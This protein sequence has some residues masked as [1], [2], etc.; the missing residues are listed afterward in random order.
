MKKLISALLACVMLVM[1]IGFVP[2]FAAE[3]VTL[4]SDNFDASAVGAKATG[5]RMVENATKK[6]FP[7]PSQKN[8]KK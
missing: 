8:R 2:T 7:L 4:H 6:I 5:L 3:P 1:S